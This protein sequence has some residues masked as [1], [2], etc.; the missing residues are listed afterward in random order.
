MQITRGSI[1]VL[2]QLEYC[3]ELQ[4]TGDSLL[5]KL[6]EQCVISY[7]FIEPHKNRKKWNDL[8]K[9]T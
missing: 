4:H 7:I 3:V 8:T 1:A 2:V 6:F 5:L 9:A